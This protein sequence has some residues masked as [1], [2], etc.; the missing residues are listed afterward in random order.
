MRK[1]E[2]SGKNCSPKFEHEEQKIQK[3]KINVPDAHEQSILRGNF[4]FENELDHQREKTKITSKQKNEMYGKYRNTVYKLRLLEKQLERFRTKNNSLMLP[5]NKADVSHIRKEATIIMDPE[6][7]EEEVIDESED[8]SAKIRLLDN[9]KL[10]LSAALG[11]L[12]HK[13]L[14]L[15]GKHRNRPHW[16]EEKFRAT[17]A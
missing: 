12:R 9:E 5:G 6:F 13:D 14:V 11:K 15:R 1:Q 7:N 3:S 16:K 17:K 4:I 2:F 10:R 8:F